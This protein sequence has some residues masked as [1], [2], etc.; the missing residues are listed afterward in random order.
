MGLLGT[1]SGEISRVTVAPSTALVI[2][3]DPSRTLKT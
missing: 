3:I 1:C 2:V